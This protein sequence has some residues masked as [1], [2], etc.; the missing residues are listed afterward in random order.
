[1]ASPGIGVLLKGRF[2]TEL[3]TKDPPILLI[4]AGENC[5]NAI[6]AALSHAKSTSKHLH[7]FQILASDLYHYG[8][9]DLVATR[10]SK[11]EFLLYIREE[12]LDRGKEEIRA[13]EQAAVEFG[14]L[15]EVHTVESEDILSTALSEAQKGYSIIFLPKT[16]KKLFPL[17][18]KT[19]AEY[20]QKKTPARIIPC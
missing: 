6:S 2:D 12:V 13:L 17:F 16:R 8:H 7:V 11:R 1:L 19:L 15:L 4:L 20:L 3:T 14:V 5:S 9:H 10:P 18:K